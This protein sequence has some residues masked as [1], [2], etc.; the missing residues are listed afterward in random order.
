M[1]TLIDYLDEKGLSP[2]E[3]AVSFGNEY[4]EAIIGVS[5][6]G[7]LVYSY[8]E[9]V[10]WL[11]DNQGWD[12]EDSIDWIDHNVLGQITYMGIKKPIIVFEVEDED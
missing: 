4:V 1:S 3:D 10:E 2:D 7:R 9:M 6:D 5:T 8:W 12:E 11:M